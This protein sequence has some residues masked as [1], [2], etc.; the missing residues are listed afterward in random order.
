VASRTAGSTPVSSTRRSSPMAASSGEGQRYLRDQTCSAHR[1]REG[2][3][4]RKASAVPAR[5]PA[6]AT[7][8]GGRPAY[9]GVQ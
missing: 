2:R 4:I 8:V 9:P 1:W 5:W 6:E 7:R 3:S